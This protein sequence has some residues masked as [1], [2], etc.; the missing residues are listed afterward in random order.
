MLGGAYKMDV[1]C[2]T[3]AFTKPLFLYDSS[4]SSV[5]PTLAGAYNKRVSGSGL[6]PSPKSPS[7]TSDT[8]Q[9]L[10]AIVPKYSYVPMYSNKEDD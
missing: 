6:Q 7:A 1:A 9:T 5:A 2:Q 4:L 10:Y 3:T 8:R